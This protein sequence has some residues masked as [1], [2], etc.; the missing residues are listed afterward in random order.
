M[1]NDYIL[2]VFFLLSYCYD[3]THTADFNLYDHTFLLYCFYRLFVY[4]YLQD[5]NFICYVFYR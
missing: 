1:W 3:E 5:A 2:Y 4:F